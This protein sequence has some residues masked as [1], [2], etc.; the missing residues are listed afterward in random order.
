[1]RTIG[2]VYDEPN[3]HIREKFRSFVVDELNGVYQS[4]SFY[5]IQ[6]AQ[7]PE[8]ISISLSP[9]LTYGPSSKLSVFFAEGLVSKQPIGLGSSILGNALRRGLAYRKLSGD[10]PSILGNASPFGPLHT[11]ILKMGGKH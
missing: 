4:D 7:S 3:D 9:R 6:S 1:M 2:I 10:T 8:Q 11:P 5:L